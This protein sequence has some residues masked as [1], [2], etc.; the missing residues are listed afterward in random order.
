MSDSLISV[1]VI[2]GYLGAGKTTLVNHILR[3]ADSRIAVLVNDFG[4]INIDESLIESNDGDTMSLSNGCICCSLVDG[5]AS[6]L[7]TIKELEPR[8]DRLVIEASGVADP[9]SIAAYGHAPG[10]AMDAVVVVVDAETIRRKSRDKYVGDTVIGQLR[11]ADILV[12]NK[13]DLLED[14]DQTATRSWLDE[15]CPESVIVEAENAQVDAMVLFGTGPLVSRHV[16]PHVHQVDADD[17]AHAESLFETWSWSS[18]GFVSRALVE[19]LMDELPESVVR[20]KG[21]IR[22]DDDPGRVTA[23]QRVGARWS[24]RRLGDW[25]DGGESRMVVIALKGSIDHDWLEDALSA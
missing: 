25:N 6:A 4:D 16:E 17:H 14:I 20:A 23:L 22:L 12:M 19:Q 18:T 10:L 5:F 24:L 13:I 8:P 21:I 2:G 15:R 7:N 1:T 3:N 11:S 9:A